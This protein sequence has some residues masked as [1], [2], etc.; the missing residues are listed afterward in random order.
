[1]KRFFI[2]CV[3]CFLIWAMLLGTSVSADEIKTENG[4]ENKDAA[5]SVLPNDG[6]NEVLKNQDY[7][8]YYNSATAE[9]AVSDTK[10]GY[11][12]YSNP[13]G[14]ENSSS[15]SKSQIVIYYYDA[16]DFSMLDSYSACI[17][18][19]NEI[20]TSCED[21][22]FT[23]SYSVG[24]SGFSADALPRVL[25]KE[26][27]EKDILSKLDEDDK[28]V[29]LKR[30]TL[31]SRNE[32]DENSISSI[33]LNFPSITKYDL[34]IRNNIP[35]Y[36]AEEVYK[37]F[38][39]AG[40][41]M[42]DLQRDCDENGIENTYRE[43]PYFNITLNYSLTDNGLTVSFDPE[44]IEYNEDTKPCRI[45]LLPYF[46]AQGTD[47]SGYMLV[48]DGCGAVINLNNGKGA[49][50]AYWKKFFNHD[51]ALTLNETP[52]DCEESVLPVFGIS[53]SNASFLATVDSGYEIA[54]LS[55]D[56]SDEGNSYNYIHT[57]FDI[58]ST[59]A[60]SLS[61]NSMDTFILSNKK[62]YSDEIVV[63]YHLAEKNAT[64][65]EL[66]LIYREYLINNGILNKDAVIDE[67]DFNID[68]IGAA[69]VKKRFLGV[70]Y[71][72]N[73]ALTTYKQ[74]LE[75]LDGLSAEKTEVNFKNSLKG[76]AKQKY[77]DSIKLQ[78][79]LGSKKERNELSE[80]AENLSVSYYAQQATDVSKKNVAITLGSSSTKVYSYNIISR[81]VNSADFMKIVSPLKLNG[82]AEKVMKS[83]K[84]N[85]IQSVNILD[86]G[87][88]LNSDFNDDNEANRGVA[89]KK[90]QDYLK[91]L[92][93]NSRVT[94]EKGSIFSL[95]YLDKIKSIP[96]TSSGYLIE[97]ATV[98]F[99]QIAISGLI[100]YTTP[101]IN[102]SAD[103]RSAFLKTVELGGQL[104][105]IWIYNLPENISDS[106]ED[107][108]K[109][110]CK[111]S[112]SQA[113]EY[114]KEYQPVYNK[115][116]GKKIIGHNAVG[117]GV[118]KTV[119]ENGTTVFVNYTDKDVIFEG[120]EIKA[121]DFAIK[122]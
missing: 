82:L 34:Y 102:E 55:A 13:Q 44:K 25:T 22:K 46:G 52:A 40:Y 10:N 118:Y 104:Q 35:D 70:P 9:I 72:T 17:E 73:A 3:T 38:L 77:A 61:S 50:N 64:Y 99:Y 96:V 79:V 108:Y 54:G 26:R 49:C 76:G 115:I 121:F 23:V 117:K 31:Y 20:N 16:Q 2:K 103:A 110:I 62:V 65:S 91:T 122:E 30:F 60:V 66:A 69:K 28:K 56:V 75:I 105:Y 45:D 7:T 120:C 98:P 18:L 41:T 21:G 4:L 5:Q 29:I 1:M 51:A 32:L 112:Y 83:L 58:F 93:K 68:F 114:I 87:Y 88:Q 39:K 119:Y 63:S 47:V 53:H 48:P 107:Y 92:S 94:A 78:S 12:W 84:L 81:Y 89:R 8:L 90:I 27:M 100:S 67:S 36:I 19:G 42:D 97:D 86:L 33:K 85:K 37:I 43:K 24:D 111:N 14:N 95:K 11:I 116:N 15:Q 106:Y 6:F 101:S 113:E 71:E 80:K 57:F 74:A 59:D 109:Y